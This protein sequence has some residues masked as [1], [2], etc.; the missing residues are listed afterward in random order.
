MQINLLSHLVTVYQF[1]SHWYDSARKPPHGESGNRTPGLPLARWTTHCK[2]KPLYSPRL[3]FRVGMQAMMKTWRRISDGNQQVTSDAAMVKQ[4][5]QQQYKN[6]N[7]G[8]KYQ[9]P[10]PRLKSREIPPPSRRFQ[11]R[12]KVPP[13]K[14]QLKSWCTDRVLK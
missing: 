11:S 10:E 5:Q 4:Q 3:T 8:S 13:Q 9:Y 1:V 6:N 14:I 12:Q 2:K 7:L